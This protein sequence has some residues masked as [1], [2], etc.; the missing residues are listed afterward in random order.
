MAK[1]N[2]TARVTKILKKDGVLWAEVLVT[3]TAADYKQTT[4]NRLVELNHLNF[5]IGASLKNAEAAHVY[6]AWDTYVDIASG[7]SVTV[8][9]LFIGGDG[10]V[11]A[12]FSY[13]NGSVT[14]DCAVPYASLNCSI[15]IA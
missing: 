6:S 5:A 2:E 1:K 8:K 3:V 11:Y 12:V 9:Q 10:V 7:T 15:V 4:A 13:N 14:Q